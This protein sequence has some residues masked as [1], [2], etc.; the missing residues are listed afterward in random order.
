MASKNV[1]VKEETSV[2]LFDEQRPDWMTEG[3]DRGNETITMAD[4]SIPRVEIVQSLSPQR[5]KND[6]A[7]IDGAEEGMMFNT[8]TGELYGSEINI[9]PALFR[10]EYVIWRKRIKG[11]GFR[12]VYPNMELARQALNTMDDRDDC[13]ILDT[14]QHFVVVVHK[15]GRTEDAVISMSKTK[16]KTSRQLNTMARMAGGDRFSRAYRLSVVQVKNDKGEFYNY[17]VKQ[18]GFPSET[19]YRRAEQLYNAIVGEGRTVNYE[20]APIE[21]ESDY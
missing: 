15:D 11:G 20:Q 10:K 18:L 4:M 2:A 3:G 19:L 13:E 12:G 8:V 9:I 6:P 14:D 17:A 16:M 5:K 7:Y 21:G 1:V